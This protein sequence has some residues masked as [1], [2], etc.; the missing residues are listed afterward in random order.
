M[1]FFYKILNDLHQNTNLILQLYLMTML[2]PELTQFYSR[3]K[4]SVTLS[5]TSVLKNGTS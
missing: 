4:T 3:T 1:I 5:F 2:N